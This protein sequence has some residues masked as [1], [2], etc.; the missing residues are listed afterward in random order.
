MLILASADKKINSADV[1]FV[2]AAWI[3]MFLDNYSAASTL[4]RSSNVRA[5][6]ESD[7]RSS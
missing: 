2:Y 3:L 7:S 4:Q 6:D 1:D 5:A